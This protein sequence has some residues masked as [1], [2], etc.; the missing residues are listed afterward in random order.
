MACTPS[1]RPYPVLGSLGKTGLFVQRSE[2]FVCACVC[3]CPSITQSKY[4]K[5]LRRPETIQTFTKAST[6]SASRCPALTAHVIDQVYIATC[7]IPQQILLPTDLIN[8][9]QTEL[10][11]LHQTPTHLPPPPMSNLFPSISS[12]SFS[13]PPPIIIFLSPV[14]PLL[15]TSGHQFP[16]PTFPLE[17]ACKSY[18]VQKIF[19]NIFY[20]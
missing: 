16:H 6:V 18:N 13:S 20:L 1:Q 3:V 2:L 19:L 7:G 10:L 11:I 15:Q 17:K 12:P 5:T 8:S 4:A 14:H 9:P